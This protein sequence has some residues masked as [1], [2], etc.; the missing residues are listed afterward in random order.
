MELFSLGLSAA[1][2]FLLYLGLWLAPTLAETI[3][4]VPLLRAAES[5]TIQNS[6]W[7][8]IRL[9]LQLVVGLLYGLAILRLRQGRE[10]AA[11][12]LGV[13]ASLL[14]IT[15]VNLLTLYLYQFSALVAV[16]ITFGFLFLLLTYRSW[17]L[18]PGS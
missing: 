15:A 10:E 17:Y 11:I 1:L 5:F 18:E 8:L 7:R 13:F 3:S 4:R 6:V 2:A 16:L 12:D 14:S 9:V